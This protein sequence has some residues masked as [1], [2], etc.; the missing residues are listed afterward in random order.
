MTFEIEVWCVQT[1][2]AFLCKSLM[3]PFC[4]QYTSHEFFYRP[5]NFHINILSGFEIIAKT[6]SVVLEVLLSLYIGIKFDFP[7]INIF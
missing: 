7:F 4:L 1:P 2:G 3:A 5:C 6:L